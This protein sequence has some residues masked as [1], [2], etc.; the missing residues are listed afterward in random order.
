VQNKKVA[1]G[2]E[3]FASARRCHMD[4]MTTDFQALVVEKS[5]EQQFERKLP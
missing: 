1:T 5:G 2:T 3:N 4:T